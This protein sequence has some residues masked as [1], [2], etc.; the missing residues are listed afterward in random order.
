MGKA[1]RR[2]LRGVAPQTVVGRERTAAEARDQEVIVEVVAQVEREVLGEVVGDVERR[3]SRR[4]GLLGAP[5]GGGLGLVFV[6][7]THGS[8]VP[9]ASLPA[10]AAPMVRPVEANWSYDWGRAGPAL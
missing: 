4:E 8:T 3:G 1:S 10:S 6:S 5:A 7:V 2:D 9:A